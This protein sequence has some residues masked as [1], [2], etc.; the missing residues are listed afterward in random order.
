ML[1]HAA[2]QFLVDAV[3]SILLLKGVNV[4]NIQK[5][6]R[7]CYVNIVPG[8]SHTDMTGRWQFVTGEDLMTT[9]E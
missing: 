2:F 5:G 3:E 6:L 1:G 8:V 7:I 9:G 4:H